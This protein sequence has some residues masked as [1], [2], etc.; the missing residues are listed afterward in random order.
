MR[1]KFVAFLPVTG[2]R[3]YVHPDSAGV[4]WVGF[5]QAV[6]DAG[7]LSENENDKFNWDRYTQIEMGDTDYFIRDNWIALEV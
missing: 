4:T 2:P 7:G 5:S 6:F 3:R 1:Q